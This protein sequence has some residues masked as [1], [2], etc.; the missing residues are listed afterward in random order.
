MDNRIIEYIIKPKN[1]GKTLLKKAFAIIGYV[2]L[3]LIL[4]LLILALSPPLLYI[5]FFLVAAA[6]V[7]LTV[8][9]TWKFLCLEYELIISGGEMTVS[10]IY[11]RAITKRL[12]SVPINS[13]LHV[14]E[15]DDTAYEALCQMSLQRNY[16]CVSSMS[17]QKM[18]YAVFD[19]GKDRC[20]IYFEAPDNAIRA[21]R[22]ANA[23]AFRAGNIKS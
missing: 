12:V 3:A 6:F 19:D 5:P 2:F 14:G 8:F 18:F 4:A 9:V 17:A 16:V 1:Q 13:F 10:V 23:A 20:V 11:G 22:Q 7:A 15:Y 21:L